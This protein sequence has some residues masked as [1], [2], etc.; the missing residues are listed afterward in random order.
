MTKMKIK[1][2]AIPVLPLLSEENFISGE[3]LSSELS[4]SRV[5]VWKQIQK[6]KQLGYHI[7]TDA[8][9]GYCIISRPDVLL[10]FE[11]QRNLDTQYIGK[12]IFYYPQVTST[13]S[14]AK[15]LIKDKQNNF[16][17]GAV[18][19]AEVQ[20]AGRGRLGR[21]WHSPSGGIWFTIILFPDLEPAYLAKIT[22]MIAVVLVQ[23][24]KSLY[25]ISVKI[26]WPNDLVVGDRKI[27]GIL[28]E[29]SAES[30]RINYV[31]VGIGINANLRSNTFLDEI[32]QQ[33]TSLQEIIG[34]PISKVILMQKIL[35][36]FEKYYQLFLKKQFESILAEWKENTE[37]LGEKVTMDYRGAIISGEAIDITSEGALLI[38]KK[39]GEKVQ[40]L[41][42]TLL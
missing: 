32:R 3:K 17:E 34:K 23:T 4:L 24:L 5:A 28:T 21:S 37:T 19:I 42:G 33:V 26:K 38:E 29:M 20:T 31:L 40:V 16:Q 12:Q 10:P 30:D 7:S 14:L 13:N 1:S 11:I 41:S 36:N 6:L 25:D 39:N 8:R 27:S 15:D 2:L 22:L 18:L 35:E 9:K